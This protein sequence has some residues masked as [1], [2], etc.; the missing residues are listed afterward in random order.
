MSFVPIQSGRALSNRIRR[1]GA[2]PAPA[3]NL[4]S[5]SSR[6]QDRADILIPQVDIIHRSLRCWG[7]RAIKDSDRGLG[8][9]LPRPIVYNNLIRSDLAYPPAGNPYIDRV[10]RYTPAIIN[11]FHTPLRCW[12]GLASAPVGPYRQLPNTGGAQI[13][14]RCLSPTNS[15]IVSSRYNPSPSVC[16]AHSPDQDYGPWRQGNT[17]RQNGHPRLRFRPI[18][19]PEGR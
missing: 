19:L 11:P 15:P 16:V 6:A 2:S 12:A 1:Y 17:Y 18:G 9:G 5:P 13:S 10:D 4:D 7:V 3:L 8:V 14:I